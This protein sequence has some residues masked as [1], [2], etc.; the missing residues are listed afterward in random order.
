MSAVILGTLV[1]IAA[2]AGLV[3]GVPTYF[4]QQALWNAENEV[5]IN[6]IRIRQQEQLIQVERQKADIRVAEAN[7]IAQAQQIINATLTDRYLQHEA[8]K[9]QEKMAGSPNTTFIY[10]PSG[11]NG[12]PIVGTTPDPSRKEKE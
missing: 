9:A 5:A 11:Q 3:F 10:I 1:V 8:I 12:I 7:G 4:R 2:A 6:A